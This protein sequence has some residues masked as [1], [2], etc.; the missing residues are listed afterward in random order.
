M[1]LL[2]RFDNPAETSLFVWRH[3]E[4]DVEIAVEHGL[5]AGMTA[6]DIGA[7]CG[8][9]TIAMRDAVGPSGRV[10]SV[11]PS[12]AACARVGEQAALNECTNVEVI[13]AA[14]G[15]EEGSTRYFTA[16]V[17]PGA[18]PAVDSTFVTEEAVDVAVVTLDRLA[19]D[20]ELEVDLIKI[21][22]DG[23][24]TAVLEG[25]RRTLAEQRPVVV[26]ELF[27]D[28]LR[29]RGSAPA[30][31]ARILVDAG[32]RLLRP[33]FERQP[34]ILARPPRIEGFEPVR[35]DDLP[36]T[37]NGHNL[38]ALHSEVSRHA[39]LEERLTTGAW[40]GDGHL[41]TL[42]RSYADQ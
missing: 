13:N 28:G 42:S 29:R 24:E 17:G 20:R 12:L 8:V 32:Y 31:Q 41:A 11:D 5:A 1:R 14:L 39:R 26:C 37:G 10:V 2:V 19:A 34:R 21:D 27:P 25:A 33:R 40:S 18:L 35:L 7:N 6:I 16:T 30:E 9:V 22:T 3:Y 23:S 15:S 36:Q 4:E 38:V